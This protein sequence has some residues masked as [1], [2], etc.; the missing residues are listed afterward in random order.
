MG[1]C[2]LTYLFNTIC[3]PHLMILLLSFVLFQLHHPDPM[4]LGRVRFLPNR[5]TDN[6]PVEDPLFETR[7]FYSTHYSHKDVR[8]SEPGATWSH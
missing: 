5:S 4:S 3:V 8:T 2:L 7:E 1:S 6:E